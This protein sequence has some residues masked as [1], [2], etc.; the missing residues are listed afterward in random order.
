MDFPIIKNLKQKRRREIA[1]GQD[2][3][4]QEIYKESQEVVLHGGTAIWRCYGGNRFSWDLD[5]YFPEKFR[6][7]VKALKERLKNIGI[8]IGKLK[9]IENSLYA[10]LYYNERTIK[11][12]G[13]FK[14][15]DQSITKQYRLV[16]GTS[17]V[18]NTLSSTNLLKEKVNAY[19]NRRKLRDLYD[20]YYLSG[21]IEEK[22]KIKPLL[23]KLLKN[24][25][26]PKSKRKLDS[27]IITGVAPTVESMLKEI[28]RWVK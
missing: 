19:L 5:F 22:K 9:T 28:K 16:D 4:I 6:F 13:L 15:K 3:V 7:S 20:I 24:Y 14:D 12:G 1:Q 17:L 21:I 26:E 8:K 23:S 27:L 2:L 18:V 25:K 11:F 10:T